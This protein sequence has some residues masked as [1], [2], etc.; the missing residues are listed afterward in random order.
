MIDANTLEQALALVDQQGLSEQTI[1]QLRQQ[2]PGCHFTWCMED[3]IH[4]PHSYRD[5]EQYRVYLV[6]SRNH[7]SI[8]TNEPA[9]ASGVVLAEVMGE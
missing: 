6:D 7:C 8:L 5:T 2:F 4:F 9:L 3:D 1:S